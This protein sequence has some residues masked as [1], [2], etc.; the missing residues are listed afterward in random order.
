M[1][2]YCMPEKG[3]AALLTL[4]AQRDFG[5][6]GSPIRVDGLPQIVP[7]IRQIL[8]GF[9][10]MGAPIYHSVRL[11][12]PDGSNVDACRRGWV[13]EGVRF[14]MPGSFG[15]EILDELKPEPG[16]R[17]DSELLLAGDFQEIGPNEEVFYRPRWGAFHKTDLEARLKAQ[18]IT[19]LVI[20]GLGSATG[21][22]ATVYEAS[23][24]DFRIIL[25]PDALCSISDEALS[26][27]GRIG[28][29]L[30]RSERFLPWI[31]SGPQSPVAA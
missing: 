13:E 5:T 10:Q 16:A 11:Y 30:V 17:L 12:R 4:A 3:K 23:A 1:T 8:D 22:K 19:T 24:R 2:D 9:R 6:P 14:L 27:L 21:T 31:Q 20:C 15:A 25:V 28:V 29:Y 26:D 18:G 7:V